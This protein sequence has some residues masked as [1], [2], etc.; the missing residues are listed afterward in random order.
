MREKTIMQ[1]KQHQKHSKPRLIEILPEKT[2]FEKMNDV[3]KREFGD[4]YASES[5]TIFFFLYFDC[6]EQ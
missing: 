4:K 1:Q 3:V 5:K 6:V 2:D